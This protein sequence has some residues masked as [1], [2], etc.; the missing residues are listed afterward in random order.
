MS[1]IVKLNSSDIERLVRKLVKEDSKKAVTIMNKSDDERAFELV[2]SH[3]K[4]VAELLSDKGDTE[5]SVVLRSLVRTTKK[6]RNKK[7]VNEGLFSKKDDEVGLLILKGIESGNIQDLHR[8]TTNRLFIRKFR[9][10]L[11]GHNV[12]AM[13]EYE[14]ECLLEVD[15]ERLNVSRRIIKRIVNKC[16]QIEG[17]PK[18]NKIGDIKTSLSRYDLPKEELEKL[19]NPDTYFSS[20]N[21]EVEVTLNQ[22]EVYKKYFNKMLNNVCRKYTNDRDKAYDYCQD[23]FIK[24]LDK[25]DTYKGGGS[26]EGWLRRSI[27]N[28][29]LDAKRKEKT[30]DK[31]NTTHNSEDFNWETLGGQEDNEYVPDKYDKYTIKDINKIINQLP[32]SYKK[33]YELY[34]VE[35]LTHEQIAKRLGIST[36]TSKSNYFKAKKKLKEILLSQ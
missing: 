22:E 16:L 33:V 21:E 6:L 34:T 10:K 9:F 4:D 29:V 15:N 35:G 11:G 17:Q 28:S 32:P 31:I 36:G 24:I 27:N 1:K 13:Y 23:A 14:G 30:K 7:P 18:Q 3:I 8:V 25:L 2:G 26:F 20:M 19:E 5:L 12:I